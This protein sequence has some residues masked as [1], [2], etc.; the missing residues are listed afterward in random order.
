ML[1]KDTALNILI[2]GEEALWV[3]P[4]TQVAPQLIL[5]ICGDGLRWHP[6]WHPTTNL[7][8]DPGGTPGGTHQIGKY[9]TDASTTTLGIE[10]GGTPGGTPPLHNYYR[11]D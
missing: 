4:K 3:A 2:F 8:M 7:G 9:T 11:G 1:F 5:L 10:S 6:R